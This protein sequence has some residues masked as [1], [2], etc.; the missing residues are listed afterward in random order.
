MARTRGFLTHDVVSTIQ[1]MSLVINI[2]PTLEQRLREEANRRGKSAAD[3]TIEVLE[4]H[5]MPEERRAAAVA[6]LQ[7]W[8]D[9]G[10]EREQKEIGDFLIRS[11]DEDRPSERKLFPPELEGV[12]W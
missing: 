3:Y 9:H 6:L 8:I 11:L 7:S 12:T 1:I 2:P 5:L 10:D 4:Q